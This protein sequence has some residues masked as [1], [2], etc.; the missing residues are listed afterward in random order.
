M[1]FFSNVLGFGLVAV[2]LCI[3]FTSVLLV[4]RKDHN[5]VRASAVPFVP[6]V[7]YGLGLYSVPSAYLGDWRGTVFLALLVTHAVPTLA[8]PILFKARSHIR[9][10]N[11]SI[12]GS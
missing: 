5:G 4:C 10:S 3:D 9:K 12:E 7:F 2:G 1:S 6:L 11:D 8:L